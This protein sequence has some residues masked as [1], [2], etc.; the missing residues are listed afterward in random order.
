MYVNVF[1]K[2]IS[3]NTRRTRNA[4]AHL[5][6]CFGEERHYADDHDD[7]SRG[8]RRRE[9]GEENNKHAMI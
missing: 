4:L 7:V 1:I 3:S 2:P 8:G 5:R 9:G 6:K